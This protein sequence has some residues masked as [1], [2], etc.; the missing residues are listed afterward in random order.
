M[1]L[2]FTTVGMHNVDGRS[3]GV[4]DELFQGMK[5]WLHRLFQ[6]FWTSPWPKDSDLKKNVNVFIL[7]Y[8]TLKL[9]GYTRPMVFIRFVY[10]KE[11][12]K[13]KLSLMILVTTIYIH[14]IR[15]GLIPVFWTVIQITSRYLMTWWSDKSHTHLSY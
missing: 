13:K 15:T 12:K 3:R 9:I 7:F 5:Y 14:K 10:N 6:E 2:S 11:V 8:S 1:P 4:D